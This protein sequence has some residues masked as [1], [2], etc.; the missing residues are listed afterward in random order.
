MMCAVALAMVICTILTPYW[1]LNLSTGTGTGGGKMPQMHGASWPATVFV[2]VYTI[3]CFLVF[4]VV[5]V[6]LYKL[7]KVYY[8][9]KA[10]EK[11]L[12]T[13][14]FLTDTFL[15]FTTG[16]DRQ[17]RKSIVTRRSIAAV[18]ESQAYKPARQ[19]H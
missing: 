10:P 18:E 2:L 15:V 4:D 17:H 6:G 5:K 14:Q 13:G 9:M 1:V 3:I 12:Y 11:Q 16:Y 8:D 7:I 19:E